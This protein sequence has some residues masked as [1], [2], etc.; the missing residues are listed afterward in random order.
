VLRDG[1]LLDVVAEHSDDVDVVG[2]G[3]GAAADEVAAL[4]S[5]LQD[6]ALAWSF[7]ADGPLQDLDMQHDI[8]VGFQLHSD[9]RALRPRLPPPCRARLRHHHILRHLVEH[10]QTCRRC[11]R[12]ESSL[13]QGR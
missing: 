4:A 10:R 8:V 11:F 1:F 3:P 12:G 13:R 9:L 2:V 5:V 6:V 7:V